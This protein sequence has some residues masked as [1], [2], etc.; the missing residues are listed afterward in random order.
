M[1]SRP[2]VD[3]VKPKVWFNYSL[4]ITNRNSAGL[5]WTVPLYMRDLHLVPGCWHFD[6]GAESKNDD[7]LID[8]GGLLC[9]LPL[10]VHLNFLTG[11]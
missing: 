4:K 6:N 1:T 3:K 10:S 2:E 8:H 7:V 5:D 9:V 11:K